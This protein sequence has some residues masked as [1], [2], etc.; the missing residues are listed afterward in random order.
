MLVSDFAFDLPDELIAQ[1]PVPRGASRLLVLDRATGA[2]EHTA[3]AALP[4]KAKVYTFVNQGDHAFY[5]NDLL[6]RDSCGDKSALYPAPLSGAEP[7]MREAVLI[8][9]D[10]SPPE[11]RT[12]QT[13]V[14]R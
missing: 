13:E 5:A 12:V 10:P 9:G 7:R 8:G 3:I 4:G 1:R 2:F 6:V 11:P 14:A